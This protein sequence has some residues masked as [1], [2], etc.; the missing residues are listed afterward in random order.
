[1]SKV[2][3]L[4]QYGCRSKPALTGTPKR[5]KAREHRG[6]FLW[7]HWYGSSILPR[8]FNLKLLK[9]AKR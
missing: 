6:F 4:K 1:M 5:Q 3:R 9:F 7:T 2:E 8:F